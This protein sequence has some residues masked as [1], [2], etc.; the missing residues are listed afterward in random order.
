MA[1]M[2]IVCPL[3]KR[4]NESGTRFCK[5]CGR[6]LVEPDLE[7]SAT[8][9]APLYESRD[10][11]NDRWESSNVADVT[12]ARVIIRAYPS[13]FD[14]EER[15]AAQT[16]G[17]YALDGQ[18]ITIG[19]GQT[20]D[21]IF[22]RDSMVSRR[23]AILRRE[24]NH[25]T[26]AD[27][28]SSNGTFLNDLEIREPTPLNHGD[29]ILIGQH[30]LLYLLDQPRAIVSPAFQPADADAPVAPAPTA[31]LVVPPEVVEVAQME[32]VAE[33]AP[34]AHAQTRP[35]A[36]PAGATAKYAS[37]ARL[38]SELAASASRMVTPQQQ[39]AELDA[40]RT[41]LVEASEA[42]TRQAGAQAALAE[43]RRAALVEARER[44][45]DL[46]ADLRGDDT[47]GESPAHPPSPD[48]AELASRV[49]ADPNNLESLRALA[50]H[51]SEL[52]QALRAQGPSEGSWR[53]ERA[54]TLR[55]LEDI[56][57][58]LQERANG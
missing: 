9:Q 52:A 45:A 19:R 24:G 18:T 27:L 55:A 25:Y 17:E 40:I 31:G 35:T 5:Y 47:Q 10:G 26:V 30:E 46:I 50:S 15:P 8:E 3:C 28:G 41:R 58:R 57:Y 14:S 6:L 38:S 29:R 13:D 54:Q 1:H 49:A 43:R 53:V 44:L 7:V 36:A 22:D 48:L 42:L 37:V 11:V 39:S 12:N 51:A 56:H 4:E 34:Q 32:Q 20:C 2:L 33:R 16:V 23:H 21:I